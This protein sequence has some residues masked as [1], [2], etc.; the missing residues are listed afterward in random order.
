MD[1]TTRRTGI[2]IAA[3][4]ILTVITQIAYMM[5]LG[6]PQ[7]ADPNVGVTN[8]D[9]ARYF[10]E[11]WAEIATVWTIELAA[12][13]VI[14]V[15]ALV[16]MVRGA[17]AP[18]AWAALLFSGV[19]N[20]IQVGIGL[21]MFRP[22]ALAGEALAPVFSVV[23]GGAFLF[24]FLAK[25]LLALAGIGFGLLL[26]A[27][28]KASAK[29][30][31]ALSILVGLVAAALNILAIP[32]GMALVFEAGAAGTAAALTTAIAVWLVTRQDA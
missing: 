15:A 3:A 19:F 24:Y 30:V 21:S 4:L 26:F 18:A 5:M 9:V 10:T 22:A 1:T 32:Q 6:G 31:G 17:P 20:V 2:L 13:A 25:V 27:R 29:V 16:A 8:A 23:V 14:A 11:R 7:A 12:F 28:E